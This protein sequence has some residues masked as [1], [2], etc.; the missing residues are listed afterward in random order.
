M[1][2][3]VRTKT[4]LQFLLTVLVLAALA[5]NFLPGLFSAY[6]EENLM[7]RTGGDGRLNLIAGVR[8]DNTIIPTSAYGVT[9]SLSPRF[10]VKYTFF[11]EKSRGGA[12]LRELSL[13][14]SWGVAVK[15]P[16]FSVL[17]PT[18]SY[19]DIN[20]FTSTAD[21][22]NVVNRAYFVM[23]R[24]IA[25]NPALV[26]QRNQQ[27]ELGLEANLGGTKISLAAFYNRTLQTA[28][29][30]PIRPWMRCRAWTSRRRTVFSRWIRLP[31]P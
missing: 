11:T 5:I 3:K 19:Q 12:F 18:P 4:P 31:A 26:W 29:S 22:N 25:Y 24:S 14:G 7:L 9:S 28:S 8:W 30:T 1:N 23:P 17:Y 21:A 2:I 20:V 16:S 6:A 27:S 10:N 13:R 15:Q